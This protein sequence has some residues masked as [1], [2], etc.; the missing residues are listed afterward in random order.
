[1][2]QAIRYQAGT[3]E[4]LDQWQLPHESH[5]LMLA[6][7]KAVWE[8]IHSMKVQGAPA[9]AMVAALGL[10]VELT[11]S[12]LPSS[13]ADLAALVHKWLD[14]LSTS[15]PTA[16]NLANM[17]DHLGCKADTLAKNEGLSV[18]A[19]RDAICAEA[20][21]MLAADWPP[22]KPL[23]CTEQSTWWPTVGQRLATANWAC[24]PIATRAPWPRRVTALHSVRR[25]RRCCQ[26]KCQSLDALFT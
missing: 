8:V 25:P 13:R 4:I 17:A 14:Y 10:A 20:E 18:E 24:S 22:T 7:A 9:I 6:D 15:R 5:Y 21:D 3:L 19:M 2:L 1:M 23:A 16:V 11:R 12:Q 26:R